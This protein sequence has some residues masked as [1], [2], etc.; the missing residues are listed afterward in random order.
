MCPARVSPRRCFR[1]FFVSSS[2]IIMSL[3]V[4]ASEARAQLPVTDDSLT[5]RF[6]PDKNYGAGPNLVVKGAPSQFAAHT[7]IR[8]SLS[9]LPTGLTSS[10]ISSATLILFAN[11]VTTAGD[12]DV[13]LVSGAWTEDTITW[14]TAP[15]LGTKIASAVPVTAS[16]DYSLVNVASA[17]QDWLSGTANNGLALVPTAGSPIDVDFDSKENTTTSHAPAISVAL[18]STGPQGPP[19]SPGATGPAGL[20]GPIGPPGVTGAQGP[21]GAAG[22]Q[23]P[24]GPPGVTGAQ[25]PVGAAGPTGA[26][27]ATGAVGPA[28]AGAVVMDSRGN[29]YPLTEDFGY[30]LALYQAGALLF[31]VPVNANGV[32]SAGTVYFSGASCSGLPYVQGVNSALSLFAASP[33]HNSGAIVVNGATATLYY[34][35]GVVVTPGPTVLSYESVAGG[36]PTGC[37]EFTTIIGSY[38]QASQVDISAFVTTFSVQLTN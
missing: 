15:A 25:G 9:P 30:S 28:G 18:V 36:I 23:G 34:P 38:Y 1:R 29:K 2:V 16:G 20:P 24:I 31:A 10:N 35:T 21:V 4:L 5:P 12:F 8:F 32:L 7:Y 22:A 17:V 37:V 19:G 6:Y 3:M 26:V 33:V 14:A 11:N 27:G 13:Y